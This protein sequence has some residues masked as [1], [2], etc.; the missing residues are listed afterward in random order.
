[1]TQ[2][3]PSPRRRRGVALAAV[4]VLALAACGSADE[5]PSGGGGDA[6]DGDEL[7]GEL[8]VF[9]AASLNE[10]F[11]EISDLF[12]EENPAAEVTFSFAGSSDLVAQLDAGAPADVLATANESTMDDAV[13]NGSIEGEPEIFVEN[14][15]TLVTPA[16]NP[17]GVTGL[18][19][20]LD[21]A[22]L[23]VCARQVPC[24]AATV[25]LAE[26]LGVTLEPVSEEN[27]V[28]DVLGKVTSG[29]ADAGLVYATDAASAGDDVDVVEVEGA[30][31]VVNRYPIS[32]TSGTEQAELADAFV[33]LVLS[34]EAQAV[35]AE[36]G[37][38]AP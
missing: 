30:E 25:T 11:E 21:D 36:A 10:V 1:M 13:A 24:G 31:D 14:V 26:N 37:F 15:L 20:S 16:G 22:D 33:E 2:I 6:S 5:D 29:Q 35:L 12:T 3:G 17:A 27:S 34:D 18:D 8:T 32:V 28:T 19:E 9:A 23:V 38:T 4:P 7:S